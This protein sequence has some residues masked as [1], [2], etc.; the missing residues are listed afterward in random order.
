MAYQ[1]VYT[2]AAKLLD[3]GRSGF[4]TVARSKTVSPLVVSAIER[5]SQFSNLRGNDRSRIIF[6]HRRIVAANN[7]F[8]L[9]SRICDAGADYT[10]RTHHI[11][12]HL[13][14]TQDEVARA[15]T[16]RLTP[17]DVLGQFS[18]LD[19]WDGAARFFGPS[20]DVALEM[21]QTTARHSQRAEWARLTG[22]PIHARSLA[23]EGA[24]RTGVLLVPRGIDALALMGEALYEFGNQA[25]S[26]SF[27]TSLETT[28]EM[29]DIDWV[30]SSPED[31]PEIQGRCGARTIL[32]LGH[33]QSLPV[34][35]EAIQMAPARQAPVESRT[36]A[37]DEPR[38]PNHGRPLDINGPQPVDLHPSSQTRAA[39]RISWPAASKKDPQAWLVPAL[40]AIVLMLLGA[41]AWNVLRPK[42]TEKI[43]QTSSGC[44]DIS[45]SD[46]QQKQIRRLVEKGGYSPTIAKSIVVIA[47]GKY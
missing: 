3:A 21:F 44:S 46:E 30:I 39:A 23:W 10:G 4:G 40:V 33:P 38:S 2:S 1:L 16:R 36:R 45:T 47:A 17:A 19:R 42:L 32:D 43:A 7:R 22:N 11:A 6:V 8:H 27:T 12:H 28:D 24:A 37:A 9:L 35:P 26:R 31:F 18:W 34:P 20:D 14:L 15:A 5:V 13:I 25:W 41:I 29:S